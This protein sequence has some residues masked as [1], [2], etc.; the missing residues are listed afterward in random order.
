ML[1]VDEQSAAGD[2]SNSQLRQRYVLSAL[3]SGALRTRLIAAEADTIYIGLRAGLIS[4]EA[5]LLWAR[6]AGV[7][8]FVSQ[9]DIESAAQ[10]M[11]L[12][13]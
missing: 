8:D 13:S 3:R 7:L 10:E 12:A 2:K 6:D 9:D 1:L 4:P 5:A 11:D